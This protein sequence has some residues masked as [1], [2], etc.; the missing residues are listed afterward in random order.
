[1]PFDW[2]NYLS[3]AQRLALNVDEASMRSAISRAYYC[4]L[5]SALARAISTVGPK[6]YDSPTH[7]WC[8]EQYKRTNN[9]ACRRLGNAGDRMKRLRVKA[10][11]IQAEIPRLN[12]EVQR[13]LRD[14]RQFLT[15]LNA[16]DPRY[17]QP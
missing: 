12:D 8:W 14:V 3:L 7:K 6:P 13:I 16:L 2:N 4:A 9:P 10:D 5:N 11:Y 1:M 17:P 15:D